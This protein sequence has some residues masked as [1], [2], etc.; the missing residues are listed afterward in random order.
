MS[1]R[2]S[3]SDLAE[4]KE[5]LKPLIGQRFRSLSLP[6][7]AI[8]A[9]EP[10][11]VGT[12]V[13]ALMDALIPHLDIKGLGLEKHE[14]ILGEREGYPDYRHESGKRLELKLLYVDNPDLKMKK[15]P[16]PREPSARLTQ[17]VTVKNVDPELDAMLLI[18][19][20]IEVDDLNQDAAVPRI[21]DLELFS[22]IELVEAR[23]K[24]MTDGGG[25]W[26]GN[27]ETPTVLSRIGQ[28]K[29]SRGIALDSVYGRKESE[30]KDFN[31]D[32][33]FG[34]LKRIPHP[35]LQEFLA[36]YRLATGTDQ[37]SLDT[38]VD[39]LIEIDEN[40]LQDEERD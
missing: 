39:E 26:F 14:G 24:R 35:K 25:R 11:Q 15:P 38:T 7:V 20:R 17:K 21:I 13:G 10:S 1:N 22:M 33:N 32:T 8:A 2:I 40:E 3:S 5:Q 29:V 37:I 16:T 19:Y 28:E 23:D 34:K 36:K 18:A 12:I 9:F 4:L 27:Y 31:E 30:G 6:I